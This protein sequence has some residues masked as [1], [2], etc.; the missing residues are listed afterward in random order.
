MRGS[1]STSGRRTPER[2]R[3]SGGDRDAARCDTRRR[4]LVAPAEPAAACGEVDYGYLLD[5]DE[6]AAARP[7]LAAA[8]GRRARALAHAS[9]P[10]AYALDRRRLDR[11]P[12]RRR[13]ALRAAHRHVHAR[14]HP[15]R[16]DRAAR[17]PRRARRRPR[18][19]A[20][21]QRLQ[22]HAQLGLRRRALVGRARGVR[23]PGGVPALRRR[24]PRGAG[25][26]SIQDVVYNHLGPC[27]NY[28]PQFGPYLKAEGENTWGSLVNLDGEGVA[29]GAPLHPRQRADVAA[30]LPRRRAPARRRAR[31]RRRLRACTCSRSSPTEVA[32][33]SAHLRPAAHP[34]RRVRPQRPAAGHRRARPAATASTRSGATTSTTR[35]TSR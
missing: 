15:R 28:L 14:G 4:R 13:R 20:A 24:L 12:A 6:Q 27:G 3:L 17:P 21:G 10:A 8:A 19:A 16:G 33:L 34:D 5:D 29:R 2:V 1:R 18:R 23:R 30:R 32:A 26:A 35:C 31:A 9:T 25:S 7:A 11:P 22:R